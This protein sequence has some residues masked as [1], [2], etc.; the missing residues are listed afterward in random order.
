[1]I[2]LDITFHHERKCISLTY[3]DFHQYAIYDIDEHPEILELFYR[4]QYAINHK[5]EIK[6]S[7]EE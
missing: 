7:E 4:L 1:M 2:R 5:Y 3:S 6:V